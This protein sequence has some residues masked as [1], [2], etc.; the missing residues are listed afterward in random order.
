[1]LPLLQQ[2]VRNDLTLLLRIFSISNITPI[3]TFFGCRSGLGL[4]EG[5][6]VEDVYK[7]FQGVKCRVLRSNPSAK[8]IALSFVTT[9]SRYEISLNKLATVSLPHILVVV[10]LLLYCLK[11]EYP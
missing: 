3:R 5:A 11:R 10:V 2:L 6:K 8:R 9:P 7:E 4:D 1:M